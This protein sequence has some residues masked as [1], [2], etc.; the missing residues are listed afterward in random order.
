[1]M[2][3]KARRGNNPV[4]GVMSEDARFGQGRLVLSAEMMAGSEPTHFGPELCDGTMA[5]D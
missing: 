4:Y 5:S 3:S 1:M 2:H